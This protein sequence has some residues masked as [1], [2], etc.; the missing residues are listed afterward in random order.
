MQLSAIDYTAIMTFSTEATI[1]LFPAALAFIALLVHW[2]TIKSRAKVA[3]IVQRNNDIP[4]PPFA[5]ENTK[6]A[7]NDVAAKNLVEVFQNWSNKAGDIFRI[8]LPAPYASVIISGDVD[9]NRE[10]LI[11]KSSLQCYS[12]DHTLLHNGGDNI[13]SS[14]GTFWQH[15]RKGMAPAFASH[16]IKRMNEVVKVQRENYV[17]SKL[18][19][20]AHTGQSFDV[21]AEMIDLTFSVICEAAFEYD[22]SPDEKKKFLADYTRTKYEIR[23]LRSFSIW[24]FASYIPTLLRIREGGKN[25][26]ALGYKILESY[27]NLKEPRSGTVVDLIAK[28]NE[29]KS[30]KERASDI[31]MLLV[32]GHGTTAHTL[33]W[34]LLELAKNPLEQQK[35]RE[36]LRSLPEE[37]RSKSDVLH[38]CIKESMRLR[39]TSLG[40]IRE[41][42]RDIIAKSNERNGLKHDLNIPKGSMIIMPQIL[43][44]SNPVT[45]KD[46]HVFRPA[47]WNVPSEDAV[48]ALMPFSVGRKNCIGQS[49]AKAELETVLAYLFAE[50]EFTVKDEGT[51]EFTFAYSPVGARLCVAKV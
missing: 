46:P 28:N 25:L 31:I 29:Y 27:R 2:K 14:D 17:R 7:L 42:T 23:N 41:T 35:L 18:D 30:D 12:Q 9:L 22:M 44:N 4:L 38:T 3:S 37:D 20:H 24:K 32:A 49:L 15:S 13:L 11:D 34:T 10:I 45:F 21:G 1:C 36:H 6:D 19:H 16:Q 50:Y 39:P 51:A 47:R 33:A 5:T 48:K 43:M 26:L 40:S 8:H